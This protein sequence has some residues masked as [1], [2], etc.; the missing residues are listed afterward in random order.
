MER[1]D[2]INLAQDKDNWRAVANAVLNL[3]IS[4]N[5]K[6]FVTA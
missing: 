5:A 6:D 1:L 4:L 3:P 2:W